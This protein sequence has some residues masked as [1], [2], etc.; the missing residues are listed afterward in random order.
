[1]VFQSFNLFPHMTALAN[2]AE[3]PRRALG[4]PRREAEARARELLTLVGLS[5][6]EQ[7]YPR[8]LSGGQQQRVAI[9]RA[10]ALYPKVLLFDKSTRA[11]EPELIEEM[12]AEI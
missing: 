6:K 11:L 2:V 7:V 8:Q 4:V 9:D 5:D 10:L 3:A 1:M 12:M